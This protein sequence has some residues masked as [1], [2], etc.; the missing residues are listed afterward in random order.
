MRHLALFDVCDNL[1]F[2]SDL[3][4]LFLLQVP[5]RDVTVPQ[6]FNF[7]LREE[8]KARRKKEEEAAAKKRE[9][10]A[11]AKKREQEKKKPAK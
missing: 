9:E 10:Q 4:D 5:K 7:L 2:L 3:S 6:P 1:K 8:E 11:N